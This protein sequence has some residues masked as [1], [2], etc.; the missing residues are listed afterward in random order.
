VPLAPSGSKTQILNFGND[1]LVAC[2]A[3]GVDANAKDGIKTVN[4]NVRDNRIDNTERI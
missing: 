2:V 3:D 1:L 4:K